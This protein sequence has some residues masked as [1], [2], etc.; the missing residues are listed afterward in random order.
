MVTQASGFPVPRGSM[1]RKPNRH[2]QVKLGLRRALGC[3]LVGQPP[4]SRFS[5]INK[6]HLCRWVKG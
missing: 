3:A 6:P 4:L 1:L 5:P 2:L